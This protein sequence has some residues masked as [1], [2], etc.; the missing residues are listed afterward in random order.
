MQINM[1]TPRRRY[2]GA[3]TSGSLA[4]RCRSRCRAHGSPNNLRSRYSESTPKDRQ[5][6]P[7][8][9]PQHTSRGSRMRWRPRPRHAAVGLSTS[10]RR[11]AT[12]R[13]PSRDLIFFFLLTF[14][15]ISALSS[16]A[17]KV[18][19]L[20]PSKNFLPGPVRPEYVLGSR[21]YH[22]RA[23]VSELVQAQICVTRGSNLTKTSA[24]GI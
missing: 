10:A 15:S 2:A 23:A 12:P 13:R 11:S 19:G 20:V 6:C 5:H 1:P 21:A 9:Q 18:L 22:A 3:P 24:A 8:S 7:R 4:P 17:V 16:R 14:L